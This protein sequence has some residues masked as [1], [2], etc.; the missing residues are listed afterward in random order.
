MLKKK[1]IK[2]VVFNT[3]IIH[4]SQK[5]VI[6]WGNIR[7]VRR[8]VVK[9]TKLSEAESKEK[10]GV[11]DPVPELTITSPE[12][13]LSPSQGLW[14]WPSILE[15]LK[16]EGGKVLGFKH[17]FL[18]CESGGTGVSCTHHSL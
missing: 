12:S 10:H 4:T 16:L 8:R 6:K 9:L 7:P 15:R 3:P 17:M 5:S 14:V 1:T 11:W 13:T 2:A 18:L